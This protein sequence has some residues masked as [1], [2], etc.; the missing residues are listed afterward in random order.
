MLRK[1]VGSVFVLFVAVA[2]LFAAEAKGK[3]KKIEKDKDKGTTI[4]LT[5]DGKDMDF[6]LKGQKGV[7]YYEG[8]KEVDLKD[9][10]TKQKFFK[11]TLKEGANVTIV[12]DKE[13][14]KITVKEIKVKK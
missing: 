3:L 2:I 6:N 9:K 5:V 4:T 10:E 11:E 1:I 14:E 8:D 13:G 7:K 12:Y